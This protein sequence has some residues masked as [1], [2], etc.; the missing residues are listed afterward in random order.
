LTLKKGERPKEKYFN[1]PRL[2]LHAVNS[3]ISFLK[4]GKKKLCVTLYFHII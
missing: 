1:N 3:K 4:A 2:V